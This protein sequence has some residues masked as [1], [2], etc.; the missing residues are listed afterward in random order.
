MHLY[1]SIT[2]FVHSCLFLGVYDEVKL[3][4]VFFSLFMRF[5]ATL[6]MNRNIKIMAVY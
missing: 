2:V 6:K 1:Q 4:M 3:E 5:S